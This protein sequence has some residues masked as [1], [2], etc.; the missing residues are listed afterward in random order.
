MDNDLFLGIEIG[1]TKLQMGLGHANGKL[2]DVWRGTVVPANGGVGILNRLENE[3]PR[4]LQKWSG[5]SIRAIGVGFGGPVN[6]DTQSIVKSH[7]ISG[8]DHF[9]IASW[10]SEKFS[11]P[12]VLGNDA[13]VAALAEA[14]HGAGATVS[15][16]FYIT[17]GS[18]IGGGFIL[19]QKIYRGVGVGAAEIGHLKVYD[20]GME[21][22]IES[23]ASGW[24]M[25]EQY[26]KKTL[27]PVRATVPDIVTKAEKGDELAYAVLNKGRWAL[28]T[29]ICHVIALLCPRKIII[30]GGV[31]LLGEER[32]FQPLRE[33]VARRVFAPFAK[34]YE[35]VPSQLGEEVVLHG[36][37]ELAHQKFSA[38]LKYDPN[39]GE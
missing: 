29:G 5:K 39:F 11:L 12:T 35:I 18:G 13:D 17:V 8:W 36:A 3:I 9:P 32:F 1:G 21:V 20:D 15:P 25:E 27:S 37:I 38:I 24:G 19:D 16:V 2:L 34:C 28:A 4:L 22:T 10:L 7:Q 6:D 14:V 26:Q 31:A 23:L 33:M 30:G